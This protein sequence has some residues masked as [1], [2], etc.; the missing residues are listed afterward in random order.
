MHKTRNGSSGFTLVE[1]MIVL[2]IIGILASFA[3]PRFSKSVYK[4][5]ASE[6]PTILMAIYNAELSLNDETGS[7]GPVEE[8]DLDAKSIESSDLFEY[9]VTSGNWESEFTAT[10]KVKAPGFG[11]A[12]A[13]AQASIDQ[14]KA[15]TGDRELVQYIK[16][17]K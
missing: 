16:T 6:F 9:T 17:W 1:L 15:K 5:K 2:V 10:A 11:E 12:K 13:G 4:T 14:D 3:I 7:F 8:L